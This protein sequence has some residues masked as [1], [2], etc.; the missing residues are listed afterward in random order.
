LYL[1]K[2]WHDTRPFF[3]VFLVIAAGAMPITAVVCLGTHLVEDFGTTVFLPTF[4]LILIAVAL[5]LGAIGAIQEFAEKTAHFLFTK[6]RSRAYFVWAGWAVGCGQLLVIALVNL[7]AGW[8]TLS[9]YSR[10]PFR[11]ALFGPIK[12]Q[13]IAGILIYALLVYG[14]TYSLT[15]VLRNGLKGLG[16]SM[17]TIIGL[18]AFAAAI[19]VRW[20]IHVPIPPLPIGGLPLVISDIAWILV[21][22]LFVF[23]AQLVVERAE[24]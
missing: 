9:R 22:L 13:D 18:Q 15:A 23:A 16:A 24:I 8:V 17:G 2:C 12:E 21:G 7:S 6:P 11:S 4:Y 10:S 20:N 3:M 5:G 19:R 14:L 1:W